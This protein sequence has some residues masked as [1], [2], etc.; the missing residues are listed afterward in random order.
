MEPIRARS[1]QG[2]SRDKESTPRHEEKMRAAFC[3]M[4][5]ELLIGMVEVVQDR[6]LKERDVVG[7]LLVG[8]RSQH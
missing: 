3:G 7:D 6:P 5:V 4:H 2:K 8:T 1:G